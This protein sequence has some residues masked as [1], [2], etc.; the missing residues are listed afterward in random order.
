M[1]KQ[2]PS[3][4]IGKQ[5][6]AAEVGRID[7]QARTVE[8]AFS[9]E[10]PVPRIYG[11]EILDHSA[12]SVD[13]TR[14]RNGA[15]LLMDHVHGDQIGV[16]ESARIDPDRVGRALVRFGSGARAN[17]IFNDVADGIR[18]NVSVGYRVIDVQDDGGDSYRVTRWQPYEISVVSVPADASVGVG[19][20]APSRDPHAEYLA[21]L[22]E[23]QANQPA[24]VFHQPPTIMQIDSRAIGALAN[25]IAGSK[26]SSLSLLVQSARRAVATGS[27]QFIT[28]PAVVGQIRLADTLPSLPHAARYSHGLTNRTQSGVYTLLGA[29]SESSAACQLGAKVISVKSSAEAVANT[30]GLGATLVQKAKL[31]IIKPAPFTVVAE[32]VNVPESDPPIVSAEISNIASGVA[33]H[34]ARFILE[35]HE[36]RDLT[37]EAI[38][39]LVSHAAAF[40]VAQIADRVLAGAILAATPT[41]YSVA[42]VATAGIR[43]SGLGALVGR[44]GAGAAGVEGGLYVSGI[45]AA[46]TDQTTATIVGDWSRAGVATADEVTIILNRMNA[47]GRMEVTILC[48]CAALVPDATNSFWVV[49]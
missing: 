32:G 17:E 27:G 41:A 45:P 5:H 30:E 10:T 26:P 6:R 12:S 4:A 7:K 37:D 14:L 40:G 16:V 46:T 8:L 18:R 31:S 28:K 22:A 25:D 23:Q 35:R 49:S 38:S 33:T 21:L 19:R 47:A 11:D 34:G 42:N 36:M 39:A 29:V 13:L 44:N 1:D 20:A 43:W 3:P 9:S 48:E 2:P 15:P 24:T